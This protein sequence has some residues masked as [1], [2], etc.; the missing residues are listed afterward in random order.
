MGIGNPITSSA[1]DAANAVDDAQLWQ[2]L[3]ALAA[4]GEQNDGGVH[5]PAFRSE[6]IAAR[7]LLLK[8]ANHHGYR[9]SIDTAANLWFRREGRD[10][11]ADPVI[12]GSYIDAQ[13]THGQFNGSLGV[14]GALQALVAMDVAGIATRRPIDAVVWT[15]Q[16]GGYCTGSSIWSGARSLAECTREAEFDGIRLGDAIETALMA[17]PEL[18]FRP[19]IWPAYCAVE[20][21]IESGPVLERTA[22]EIG[23]VTTIL[24]TRW[25]NIRIVGMSGDAGSIPA[26][27]R[28]DAFQA[29]HRAVAMLNDLLDDDSDSVRFSIGSFYATPNTRATIIDNVQFTIDLRHSNPGT[30]RKLGDQIE[31]RLREAVEPCELRIEE[32]LATEPVLFAEEIIGTVEESANELGMQHQR[33]VSGAFHDSLFT[34]RACPSGMIF[35]PSGLTKSGHP[36]PR[37]TRKQCLN[38]V[39]AL[40]AALVKLAE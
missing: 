6:D 37:S 32:V 40:T 28:L 22:A 33:M 38:G 10:S 19:D 25:F 3:M 1:V 8:W 27:D 17:T 12:S 29:A 11:T 34:A 13:P 7:A 23:A 24:G 20:L 16:N 31:P 18:V 9:P 2:R 30:L 15:D 36:Y 39:Q 14:V 35:V 26:R 5:R 4:I 21:H